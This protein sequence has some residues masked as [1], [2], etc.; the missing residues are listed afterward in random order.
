MTKNLSEDL[1]GHPESKL[2]LC[3]EL[4][5]HRNLGD[6]RRLWL[7]P[8]RSARGISISCLN[9]LIPNNLLS[10]WPLKT[11]NSSVVAI[12]KQSSVPPA[13]QDL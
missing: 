8:D 10:G 3:I 9:L 11:T 6:V 7:F 5:Q 12:E 1:R 4:C 2:L 13:Y